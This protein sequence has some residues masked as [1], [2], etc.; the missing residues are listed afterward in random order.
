ME[1]AEFTAVLDEMTKN[2]YVL[3]VVHNPVVGKKQFEGIYLAAK[4]PPRNRSNQDEHS[5]GKKKIRRTSRGYIDVVGSVVTGP[6]VPYLLM[7]L[8]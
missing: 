6:R 8:C 2:T 1:L 3:V 4:S 5:N 7:M